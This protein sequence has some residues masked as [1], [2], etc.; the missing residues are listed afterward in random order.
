MRHQ[1]DTNSY[2]PLES[3]D[4][5]PFPK[6]LTVHNWQAANA[7]D[8][9]SVCPALNSMANH[10]YLYVRQISSLVFLARILTSTDRETDKALHSPCYSMQSLA[11]TTLPIHFRSS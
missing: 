11:A 5:E 8:S 10:G 1:P 6:T 4:E 2:I 3:K 7:T 9:R